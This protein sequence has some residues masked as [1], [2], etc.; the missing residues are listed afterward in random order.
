MNLQK[1]KLDRFFDLV[2]PFF[3]FETQ[4]EKRKYFRYL[5]LCLKTEKGALFPF[6]RFFVLREKRIIL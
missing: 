3:R 1:S 2:F 4:N 6:F 5:V